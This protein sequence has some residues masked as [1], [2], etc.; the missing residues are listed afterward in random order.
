M[1]FPSDIFLPSNAKYYAF[2]D[3]KLQYN[4]HWDI[5]WS[6]EYALSGTEAGICTFLTN[7]APVTGWPGH[8]LGYSGNAQL[9]SYL[10]TESGEYILTENGERILIDS[11]T[12]I[13]NNGILAIG[14]DSTGLFALSSESRGGVGLG[15]VLPNSL[16][17]RNSVDDVVVNVQ[18]SALNTD[19]VL[20]SSGGFNYQTLRFRYSQAG[21]KLSIDFKRPTDSVFQL[22]TSIVQPFVT[23]SDVS[24]IRVGL[25]Y[26]SPISAS[27]TSPG[28]MRIRNFHTQGNIHDENYE[29]STF[30]PITAT[31]LTT[32]TTLSSLTANM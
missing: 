19:F 26:C 29:S 1:A 9:S 30:I 13:G 3:D 11:E 28:T 17:I 10:V 4:P 8:Y 27:G 24:D 22:L 16:V 18:L 12:G 7:F 21:N 2:V 32:Y 15:S 20:M 23:P 25:C 6:L 5:N 31:K 14:F